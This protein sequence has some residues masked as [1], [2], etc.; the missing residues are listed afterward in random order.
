MSKRTELLVKA[1]ILFYEKGITQTDIAITLGISRPTVAALL[2]EAREK[3]IVRITIQHTQHHTQQKQEELEK[4]YN[5]KSVIIAPKNSG[6]NYNA[7]AAVGQSCVDF[8]EQHLSKITSLGIG[9]GTTIYEYVQHA[10]YS[11]FSNLSIVPLIGGMGMSDFQYHSTHLAFILAQ[12]YNCKANYFYAPAIAETIKIKEVLK[13]TELVN[14]V[15]S[16]GRDVSMAVVG[17]GNPIL[18]SSYRK[19]GY[20]K[21]NDIKE[22]ENSQAI[23][24]ICATF[25]NQ[26]G[27]PVNSNISERMLGISLD[28]LIKI[29]DV[30]VLATGKEKVKS[31]KPLIKKNVINHLIIDSEIA[32]YL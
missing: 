25:F 26:D 11:N 17:V 2:Q 3:D 8:I 23:G 22:I 32:E 9:W 1:A 7:K 28:D 18:S 12:K 19:F 31:I 6:N 21:E 14:S 4:K 20:I 29:P 5:I 24:D 13:N 16:T 27:N 30:V 10:N 15:L